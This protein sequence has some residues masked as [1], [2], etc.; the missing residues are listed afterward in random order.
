[1]MLFNA[2][3]PRGSIY[4]TPPKNFTNGER[5]GTFRI[6]GNQLP[7]D[8]HSKSKFSRADFAVAQIDEAENAAQVQRRFSFAY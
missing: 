7:E 5:T 2:S 4:A 1:M 6:G 8:S 3:H